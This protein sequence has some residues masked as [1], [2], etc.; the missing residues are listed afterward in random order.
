MTTPQK[1][2][3]FTL[4]ELLVVI[5]II[6][7]L[8]AILFPVFARARENAR[9]ASCM[10]NL[11]Q[12]G[13]GVMMYTQDYD[14]AYPFS[15]VS[16]TGPWASIPTSADFADTSNVYWPQFIYP[17]TKSM[18]IFYC[19]SGRKKS[20]GVDG[21][22]GQYGVNRAVLLA[23]TSVVANQKTISMAAMASPTA[24]Y[25]MMDLG[26]YRVIASDTRNL[27]KIAQGSYIP[28]TG[29]GS[30]VNLGDVTM[31]SSITD[32]KDDYLS[33][34]HL[35]G[36]NVAFADG[37]VKWLKSQLVYLE[38]AKCPSDCDATKSAWNPLVD[39]S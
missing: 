4:I 1:R 16:R 19:P 10:S 18:D 3:G 35:G 12:I 32:L 28:G 24:T 20:A 37:H 11:K 34:R 6:S 17:Y 31:A 25:M 8:A 22:Y 33:G 30:A 21:V 2:R 9:R 5:A 36:V 38:A 39:N 15:S 29:P 13:L 27:T 7:I 14:E 26:A 23:T